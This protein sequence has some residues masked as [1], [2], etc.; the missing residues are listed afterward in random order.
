MYTFDKS[1]C[2][3]LFAGMIHGLA[4]FAALTNCWP[5]SFVPEAEHGCERNKK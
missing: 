5:F 4:I 1:N 2:T 3:Q